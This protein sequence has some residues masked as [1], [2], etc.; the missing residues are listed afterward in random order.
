MRSDIRSNI[1]NNCSSW[2]SV[3]RRCG[4]FRLP[5][6]NSKIGLHFAWFNPRLCPKSVHSRRNNVYRMDHLTRS[7]QL[8]SLSVDRSKKKKKI[9]FLFVTDDTISKDLIFPVFFLSFHLSLVFSTLIYL[10]V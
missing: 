10:L 8:F 6:G 4:L 7:L 1:V 5:I 3:N 2:L 9:F